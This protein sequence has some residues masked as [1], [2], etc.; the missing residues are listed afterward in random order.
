MTVVENIM[1]Q[2]SAPFI[3]DT[4][5][6]KSQILEIALRNSSIKCVIELSTKIM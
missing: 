2:L 5:N 4:G 3:S 6:I 1:I